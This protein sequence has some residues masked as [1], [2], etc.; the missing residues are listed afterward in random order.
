MHVRHQLIRTRK[1]GKIKNVS[2]SIVRFGEKDERKWK[3]L[4]VVHSIISLTFSFLF[5]FSSQFS[6]IP[7]TARKTSLYL[8]FNFA[9]FSQTK[10]WKRKFLYFPLFSLLS[11]CSKQRKI[12]KCLGKSWYYCSTPLIHL[13]ASQVYWREKLLSSMLATRPT[14]LSMPLASLAMCLIVDFRH[15]G[16][17]VFFAIAYQ[18]PVCWHVKLGKIVFR[19]W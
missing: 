19:F 1:E 12:M 5:F 8:T 14:T 2:I 18:V 11:L 10:Q 13:C 9:I 15:R 6:Q 7:N 16:S 17:D 3:N 4:E